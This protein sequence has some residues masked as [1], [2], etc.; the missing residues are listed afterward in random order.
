MVAGTRAIP[1]FHIAWTP[2][3]A[4]V[5][6]DGK[7]GYT[8]GTNRITAPDAAGLLSTVEGRYITV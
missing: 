8:Y 7:L 3:S 1:G 2:D 5:S 6:P 4:V